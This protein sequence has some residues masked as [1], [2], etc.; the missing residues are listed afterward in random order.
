MKIQ[1]H[2]SSG[3]ILMGFNAINLILLFG[4]S[5][6]FY[7]CNGQNESENL[8][9]SEKTITTAQYVSKLDERTLHVFQDSKN[10][11]WFGGNEKGA[12]KYD[13]K[14][15]ILYTIK[16]GLVGSD[17][18]KIQE[19]K[20]G[21]LY[22]ETRQGV[23]KFDGQKFTT[24]ELIER[25]SKK[26]EWKLG[27]NDL[28]FR[29]GFNKKGPYRYDG[30]NLYSLEF[31]KSPQED[32]FY[33]QRPDA[34]YSPYGVYSIYKDSKGFVWFGT[35]GLGLCRFDGKLFRWH[36]EDQL[37]STPNGG[38]FGM[39]SIIEVKGGFFWFN[40]SRYRYEI[41]MNKNK[42]INYINYKK[43][44]GV[45]YTNEENQIE[46]P[47]FMSSTED[48]NGDLWMATY[49][50]GVWRNNGTELIHYPI[51]DGET[52]V[53]LFSI[54][55]DNQGV[56][57]LGTHNAGVYKYNGELFEKFEPIE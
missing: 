41:L 38:D 10:N 14:S 27:S 36:Y 2:L 35:S 3:L 48:N 57:W 40:N 22:F 47:Y 24:L 31:P 49:D 44:N 19:D 6:A 33:R 15:L 11:V 30:E 7:S 54:Y 9:T 34:S 39:R 20:L 53:L 1:E 5:S 45:G 18:I 12:Y 17:I 4:V 32:E 55:K 8:K 26:N 16:E 52:D 51:K 29:L 21:N 13:G 43:G 50:N 37:Q 46:F 28:W 23:S 56:L 42:G 25:D